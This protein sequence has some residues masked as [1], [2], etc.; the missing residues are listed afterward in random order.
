[1]KLTGLAL[2]EHFPKTGVLLICVRQLWESIVLLICRSIQ[3]K[4]LYLFV[5]LLIQADVMS[6][7]TALIQP[8]SAAVKLN[9]WERAV[10]STKEYHN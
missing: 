9:H 2:K 4:L 3:L 8:L 6:S 7:L 5:T 1:V 10:G